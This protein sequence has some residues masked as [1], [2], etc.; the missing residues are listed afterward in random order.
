MGRVLE[1][2]LPFNEYKKKYY[3]TIKKK[4]KKWGRYWGVHLFL[5][6]KYNKSR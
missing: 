5:F 6:N 3:N 2:S 1:P 4:G